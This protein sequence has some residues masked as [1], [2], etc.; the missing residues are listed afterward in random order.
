MTDRIRTLLVTLDHDFRD[1]DVQVIVD[2]IKM[3]KCVSNVKIGEVVDMQ[4]HL[5]R[6]VFRTEVLRS[7]VDFLSLATR[8]GKEWE[9]IKKILD[10][11]RSSA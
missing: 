4:D 8:G 10:S 6:E 3:I 11:S 2:A 5:N 1:D 7:A 9:Q